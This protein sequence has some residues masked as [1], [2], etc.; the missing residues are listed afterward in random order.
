M[1][2][3]AIGAIG[4]C[5]GSIAVFVTLA[6][7]AVQVRHSR[8]EARRA[9]SQTRSDGARQ[10]SLTLATDAE[11]SVV[12]AKARRGIGA[13]IA[14]PF[15]ETL[16]EKT[17]LLREE[18]TRIMSFEMAHWQY[19]AQIIANID[20]LAPGGRAQFDYSTRFTYGTDPLTRLWYEN[21]K[22]WLNPDAVRYVDNLLAQQD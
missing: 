14:H 18:A 1:N 2:W 21:A 3:D 16:V 5:L 20:E 6:Y 13:E 11:L 8:T 9:I 19:R 15:V 12:Y 22:T 10:H 17:G 7:L 4:Q